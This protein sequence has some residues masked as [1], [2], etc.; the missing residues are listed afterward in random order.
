MPAPGDAAIVGLTGAAGLLRGGETGAAADGGEAAG[1]GRSRGI[2]GAADATGFEG[3]AAVALG[4][5]GG[6]D[7]TDGAGGDDGDSVVG[8]GAGAWPDF[9]AA[10]SS[11]IR[12]TVA[13]SRLAKL[14]ALTSRPQA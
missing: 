5:A 13:G 4:R 1:P 7:A 12:S 8:R 2:V 14:L 3:G 10:L 11:L 9:G 6:A